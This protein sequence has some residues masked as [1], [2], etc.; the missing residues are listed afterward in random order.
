MNELKA[1]LKNDLLEN[2][3]NDTHKKRK[4]K[5]KTTKNS[6]LSNT[7]SSPNPLE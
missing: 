1:K 4:K 6:F 3:H 7:G 2:A 5:P